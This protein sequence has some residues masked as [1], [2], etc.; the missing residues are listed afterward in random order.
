M[1]AKRKKKGKSKRDKHS[2]EKKLVGE[3]DLLAC[4]QRY[5]GL[6]LSINN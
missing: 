1:K 2:L 3:A 6:V 5:I 4:T